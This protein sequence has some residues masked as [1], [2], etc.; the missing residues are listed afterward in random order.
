MVDRIEYKILGKEELSGGDYP[1]VKFTLNGGV[2]YKNGN[3]KYIILSN[4]H[5]HNKWIVGDKIKIDNDKTSKRDSTRD[6]RRRDGVVFRT[7][8]VKFARI[9]E[10]NTSF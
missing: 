7:F 9:R 2:R 4:F 5:P 6:F 3:K 1:R 8:S 10:E